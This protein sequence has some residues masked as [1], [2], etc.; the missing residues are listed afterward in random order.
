MVKHTQAIRGQEPTNCLSM[1]DL[2]VGLGLER[3]TS[4]D[5][6]HVRASTET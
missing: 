4:Y 5:L 2:F 1:Y 3:L 6:Q